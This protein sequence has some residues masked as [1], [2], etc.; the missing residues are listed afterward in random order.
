MKKPQKIYGSGGNYYRKKV[1]RPDG[2]YDVVYGKTQAELAE[3]VIRRQNILAAEGNVPPEELYFYE[4]ASAWYAR[5]EP[6]LS[7]GMKKAVRHEVNDV[8]CP[9]IGGKPIR[10]ITSDDLADVLATR[11]HLSRSAQQKT[12]MVLKQIFDAALDAGVIEKL[13]T[14]RLKPGGKKAPPKKALTEAQAVQLLETVRGLSVEPCVMLGLYTGMRREEICALK[15][16]A[17]ELEGEA[18]HIIVRR[19]CRWPTNNAAEISDVLKTDAAARSIPIPSPL[20]FYLQTLRAA[21]LERIKKAPL[22]KG[23]SAEGGGGYILRDRCVYGAADGKP[24][25]LTAFRRRWEAIRCRSTASGRALGEKVRNHRYSITLDFYPTPHQLRH[26]Y[27]TRLI[28]GGVDLKR[29]QYLAGHADPKVTLQIYTDLMG[30]APEDL[31][32]DVDRIFGP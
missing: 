3:K 4:Y 32:A 16:D 1:R 11:G 13:P 28:L 12:V 27:I 17:V 18:P 19:A 14:R 10:E 22:P 8:I 6:H 26:T 30:H 29:V 23:G 21:E 24:L 7:D 15:W 9:V 31:I 2:G 5:R 20:R 25:S